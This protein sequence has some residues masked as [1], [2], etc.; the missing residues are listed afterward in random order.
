MYTYRIIAAVFVVFV[1]LKCYRRYRQRHISTGRILL[2]IVFW[3]SV[4]TVSWMP[5]L[6]D[7]VSQLLG[8][9]Q[10]VHLAFFAVILLMLYLLSMLYA[11]LEKTRQEITELVRLVALRDWKSG[12]GHPNDAER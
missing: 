12:Q 11:Q 10:G 6:T 5:K 8:V 7:R 4:L 3:C 9:D 2:W 1:L